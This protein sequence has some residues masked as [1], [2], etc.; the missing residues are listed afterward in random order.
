MKVPY[1]GITPELIQTELEAKFT[2]EGLN[3]LECRLLLNRLKQGDSALFADVF[4]L[5]MRN[6]IRKQPNAEVLLKF[7]ELDS[8][9][10]AADQ[11]IKA[12]RTSGQPHTPLSLLEAAS[13]AVIDALNEELAKLSG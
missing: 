7:L 13:N 4:S 3:D 11:A 2:A 12:V 1:I 8:V 9:G 6:H 10:D 5:L